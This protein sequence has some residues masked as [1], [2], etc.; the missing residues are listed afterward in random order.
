[1]ARRTCEFTLTKLGG[2]SGYPSRA[3]SEH[4]HIEHSHASAALSTAAGMAKADQ[5]RGESGRRIVT[6]VGD[7]A[8]TGGM[9]WEALNDIAGANL[10]VIIIVNDNGRSYAPTVGGLATHLAAL[11]AAGG[12]ERFLGGMHAASV[13]RAVRRALA[14]AA[15]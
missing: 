8:L 13:A 4:D 11:R 7:G 14:G 10:P 12:Y 3:E 1:M 6:I 15:R 5:L 2:L 9:S